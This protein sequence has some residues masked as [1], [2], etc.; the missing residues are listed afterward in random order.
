[1]GSLV[2]QLEKF[3]V[4]RYIECPKYMTIVRHADLED[5]SEFHCVC[6]IAS[7]ELG[8]QP[9]IGFPYYVRNFVVPGQEI[10]NFDDEVV[11]KFVILRVVK[12]ENDKE[13]WLITNVWSR[14]GFIIPIDKLPESLLRNEEVTS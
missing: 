6:M 12:E 10:I 1:M 3:A 8:P 2:R 14:V 11:G 4:E 9:G 7:P 5:D 13:Y